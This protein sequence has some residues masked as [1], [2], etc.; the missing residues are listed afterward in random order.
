MATN[1]DPENRDNKESISSLDIIAVASGIASSK[2]NRRVWA[3]SVSDTTVRYRVAWSLPT[4]DEEEQITDAISEVPEVDAPSEHLQ[5]RM[6]MLTENFVRVQPSRI[7]DRILSVIQ[8]MLH[9]PCFAPAIAASEPFSAS[10]ITS[11]TVLTTDGVRIEF[12]QLPAQSLDSDSTLPLRIIV[13]AS[14]L[15]SDQQYT[16]AIL[17]IADNADSHSLLVVP[18]N[19]QAKGLLDIAKLPPAES[20]CRLITVHL[21]AG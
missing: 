14:G 15:G 20:R 9:L 5:Q 4:S 18:L 11:Q 2:T 1:T 3:K 7:P 12:Q 17:T 13:D 21:S 8:T 16:K 6:Q 19:T 10:R